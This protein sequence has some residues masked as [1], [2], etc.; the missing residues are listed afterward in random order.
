MSAAETKLDGSFS[1]KQVPP[2]T[3][4][5][6]AELSGYLSPLS[7]VAFDE[8]DSP[9]LEAK[10]LMREKLPQV[11]VTGDEE[12]E[13]ELTLKRGAAISGR[14]LYDDGSPVVAA[15]ISLMRK[16]KRGHWESVPRVAFGGSQINRLS[17][18]DLGRYRLSGLPTSEYLVSADLSIVTMSATGFLLGRD[19]LIR[20]A[21]PSSVS[22]YL[23]DT[24]RRGAGK[25]LLVPSGEEVSG[26]DIT[27]PLSKLHSVSGIVV[28]ER[29]GHPLTMGSVLL[30]DPSDGSKINQV[31]LDAT[32]GSFRMELVPE[33]V[34]ILKVSSAADAIVES[35]SLPAPQQGTFRHLRPIHNYADTEQS[36]TISGDLSS[37]VV[38]MVDAPINSDKTNAEDSPTI[39]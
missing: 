18:D 5:I 34:Y 26:V 1:I 12:A 24:V 15:S 37:V 8:T 22:F 6:V 23:G 38:K 20:P 16:D 2:G 21:T 13:V 30:I 17:T 35:G 28:S 14:V 9:T 29:D 33:G 31:W 39:R 7:D 25:G 32:T 27:V 10:R 36:L 3:Y 4:Y 19:V 11:T